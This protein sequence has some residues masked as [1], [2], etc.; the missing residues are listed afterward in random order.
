MESAMRALKA[1]VKG[2]RLV[3]DEPT[4]LPEGTEVELTLEG[5]EFD[6]DERRRLLEAIEDGAQD[7]ERGDHVDG[8]EFIAQLRLCREAPNR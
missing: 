7:V 3:L 1:H 4:D 8:A 2:G 6:A 5:A